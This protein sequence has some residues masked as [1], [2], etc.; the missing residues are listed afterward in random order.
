M[1]GGRDFYSRGCFISCLKAYKVIYKGCLYQIVIVQDLESEI[2]PIESVLVVRD[3]VEV[4]PIGIPSV[5][6]K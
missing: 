6:P 3:F 5:P 1:K 2:P 4:F